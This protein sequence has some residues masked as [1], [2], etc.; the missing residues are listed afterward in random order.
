MIRQ[1]EAKASIGPHETIGCARVSPIEGGQRLYRLGVEQS[2][3]AS[4]LHALARQKRAGFL[5]I[6]RDNEGVWLTRIA[7]DRTLSALQKAQPPTIEHALRLALDV[8]EALAQPSFPGPLAPDNVLV[9]EGRAQLACEGQV[10]GMLGAEPRHESPPPLY[11]PPDQ[12]DG[13]PFDESANLYV[14]GLIL[15]KM[16]TGSHPFGGAGL[17]RAMEAARGAPPPFPEA[18][19]AALPPGL[20]SL[21]LKLLSPIPAERP[22]SAE[23]VADA[24]ARFVHGGDIVIAPRKR[25]PSGAAQGL[26]VPVPRERSAPPEP[27]APPLRPQ[28]PAAKWQRWQRL[29]PLPLALAATA[30]ALAQL[31]PAPKPNAPLAQAGQEQANLKPTEFTANDCASCHARQAN[32]WRRSVMGHAAKSPLFNSLESLI[33]EQFG[34]DFACPNGAGALRKADP[35]TACR[36]EQTGFQTTGTGGE[37]WCVNCHAPLESQENRIPAWQGR[38]GDARSLHPVRD[39]LGPGGL[40]GIGCGSCHQTH[41]PVDPSRRG[42]QGNPSWT[43]FLTGRVFEARPEDRRR[44]FG[45]GNSGYDLRSEELF[46][47][48]REG[49]PNSADG[50][51]IPHRLHD[52]S[53][54]KYLKSSEFC[55]SCH[56]VRLFGTDAVGRNKGENFKRL[57][58]GYTEWTEWAS[59]QKRKGRE[60]ATCQDCHMSAFPGVCTEAPGDEGDKLCGDGFRFEKRA[61]G[62]Y[63]EGRIAL[64]SSKKTAVTTHFF[65]GVDLPLSREYPRDL[66]DEAAHDLAQ[67]PV[68]AKARRDALL[69]AT[70]RFELQKP[71]KSGREIVIPIELENIGAGHRAPAGFSQEREI[72][73]HLEVKDA[74]GRTVYEVGRVDRNDED[75]RDK[76]FARINTDPN[77]LDGQGRPIGLFGADIRNGPD[78]PEWTPPP[79]LGGTRFSG[80]GL[81]NLQNGFL[82]CVTCIGVIAA[83]GSCQ[84][85]PGQGIFRADRFTDGNYD[86]DS[87][88]CS[89]NLDDR[90]NLFETYFPVGSLDASRGQLKAPD[91]IIDTRSAPPEVPLRYTYVLDPGA[92]VFPLKVR[93][94]LMFRAFPPF[95]IRAFIEYE[96]QMARLGRRPSGPLMDDSMWQ[97]IELVELDARE[98]ELAR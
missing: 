68:S 30:L 90:H 70:F 67:I 1:A 96:R 72:W 28:A 47:G 91:A 11:C 54:S 16:L 9:H 71:T 85:G 6:G 65:S 66:L 64:G 78:N 14:L 22:A 23:A 95:L 8:A 4:K 29:W 38:G 93:A 84:P 98:A 18:V 97:R 88:V 87:G 13:A 60:A 73:V 94:R 7:A 51:E 39:L 61:P 19:A 75:L 27:V 69:R 52:E 81:I 35:R 46:L 10:R 77:L 17:R 5:E 43:S 3:L 62:V 80:K 53:T 31:E 2:E 56:D 41:G 74:R 37:H 82:R 25:E 55:G 32:E 42:Y 89:S 83:D 79:E 44:V 20:Q 34:R 59:L 92:A 58:N 76:V 33:Q 15:Y 50:V 49:G 57:R 24:L 40:D 48:R 21:T 36:N 26:A 12:A 86:L 45:I 63:P